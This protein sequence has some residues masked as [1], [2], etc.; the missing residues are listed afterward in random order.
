M[1]VE[2]QEKPKNEFFEWVKAIVIALLIAF[3]VKTYV[4]SAIIVDGVSMMPT[5]EHGD[6]MFVNKLNYKIS[7]PKR[8]DIVIFHAPDGSDYI[9]RVIGLPGDTVAYEDDQLYINGEAIDEPY[10]D[11][12]KA[13]YDT[14]FTEDFTLEQK[15]EVDVVPEGHLFVLGDN[16]RRSNDSRHYDVGFIPLDEFVGTA[17]VRFWPMSHVGIVK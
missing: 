10:L 16:R 8:F 5:L 17:S 3:V 13:E 12:Y 9:K 4:V 2:Q 1:G 14:P 15:L 7:D 6:R 11:A